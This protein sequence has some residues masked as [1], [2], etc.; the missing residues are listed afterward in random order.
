MSSIRQDIR[1]G[2]R[3]FT[4]NPGFTLIVI[5]SLALGIGANTAIFSLVNAVLMRPLPFRDSEKLVMV[6]EDASFVG[7]PIN[8]PAPANYADWKSQSHSFSDMAAVRSDTFNLTGNA[9][10]LRVPAYRAT[11]NF[12]SVLGS[13]PLLGRVFSA[14]EDVPGAGNVAILSYG[15]WQSRFGGQKNI[16]GSDILLNNSKYTVIGVMPAQFQFMSPEIG[17]WVPIGFTQEQLRNRNSHYLEVVARIKDGVTFDRAQTEIKTIMKRI[18]ADYPEET[19]GKLGAFIVPIRD[20]LVGNVRRPL[21]LLLIA[22]AFV[23]LIACANIA[24]LLL[25]VAASRKKEIALRAALGA[26]KKRLMKQLLTESFL[27]SAIGG[28]LG[29]ILGMISFRFLQQLVPPEVSLSAKLAIDAKV[30]LYTFAISVITAFIFGIAPS[31]Q[32]TRTDLNETLKAGGSRA[33][34]GAGANKFRSAMVVVEMA[35]ALILLVGAGL[36]IQTIYRLQNLDLG[37]RTA[38]VVRLRTELPQSKYDTYEK[39]SQFYDE[40]LD[41]VKGLPGVIS[42]GYSTSVPLDWKGGTSGYQW[43][44]KPPQ[45]GEMLDANHRQVTTDYLQTLGIQLVEG[46]Y[47]DGTESPNSMPVAI[48]N[49]AMARSYSADTSAIGRKFNL[50]EDSPW[51]TVIGVVRNIRNMGLDVEPK[52]E[53]YLPIR[54]LKIQDWY[55]PQDLLVRMKNDPMNS[56]SNI[57]EVIRSIDN[58]LPI[59][60]VMTLSELVQKEYQHRRFTMVLLAAFA[61]LALLLACLGVYGVLNYFVNQQTSEIGVRLALGAQPLSILMLVL[62]R[63]MSLAMI[64]IVFGAV[65]AFALTKVM[66]TLLFEVSARDPRTFLGVTFLLILLA[67]FASLIPARRAMKTSPVMALRY[68]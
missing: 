9:E 10:P 52:P 21:I 53:M 41:R 39:R 26:D 58:D 17:I 32:A 68:E 34:S 62:K 63:G 8:T 13:E 48:V 30:L 1:Y 50:G 36:L 54:Q 57:R 33:G 19:G 23:L 25:S 66:Q 55:A 65:G 15:L 61:G 27:L 44:G 43:E 18:V 40:V 2:F 46:R 16:V 22:V 4:R 47:F 28:F 5:L 14:K 20:Q 51:F 31:L 45:P 67:L 6:W 56:I 38:N 60:N 64:G 12:F 3:I 7:F 49:E 59:S 11:A 29:L 24:S 35:F 42:A 37:F